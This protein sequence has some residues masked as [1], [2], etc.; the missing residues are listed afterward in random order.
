M[1]DDVIP[2]DFEAASAYFD[3][4]NGQ[5][6]VCGRKIVYTPCDTAGTPSFAATRGP[7][8]SIDEYTTTS[9]RHD[10]AAD[11]VRSTDTPDNLAKIAPTNSN[12]FSVSTSV[13]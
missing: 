9:G 10:S 6:G 7:V 4:I 5:G 1:S 13:L 8:P 2:P 11:T 12:P 3:Y